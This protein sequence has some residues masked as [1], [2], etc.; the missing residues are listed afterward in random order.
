MKICL[1]GL[2]FLYVHTHVLKKYRVCILSDLKLKPNP[3]GFWPG[4]I[5][6]SSHIPIMFKICLWGGEG[7]EKLCIELWRNLQIIED[8]TSFLILTWLRMWKV[9]DILIGY[10]R[11]KPEGLLCSAVSVYCDRYWLIVSHVIDPCFNT[12]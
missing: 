3:R 6:G 9:G 10:L 1:F 11:R 8:I 5:S 4:N 2:K 7:E 12:Y